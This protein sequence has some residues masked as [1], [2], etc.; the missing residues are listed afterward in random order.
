MKLL[1]SR[2][3]FLTYISSFLLGKY[4]GEWVH[5]ELKNY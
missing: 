2:V 1:D 5:Q 4:C 3:G